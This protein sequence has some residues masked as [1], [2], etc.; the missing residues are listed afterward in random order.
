M[1]KKKKANGFNPE[2]HLS[3]ASRKKEIVLEHSLKKTQ[4]IIAGLSVF[5]IACIALVIF[6]MN[7]DK[8]AG[9][10][11]ASV[12]KSENVTDFPN[13][14][15]DSQAVSGLPKTGEQ[16]NS[17]P[18]KLNPPHGQPGHRC[19]IQVGSPLNSP[20][21]NPAPKNPDPVAVVDKPAEPV[22]Q[23]KEEQNNTN[24]SE[25]TFAKTVHD[26]GT[27]KKES[28]GGCEFAFTNTGTEP[29][30]LSNV[31]SSC[32][33]TVPTWPKDPI[34]PGKSE[35]IKVMYDTKRMGIISK[36]ITVI[37]NAKNGTVILS[38]KGEVTE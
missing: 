26:Y 6:F 23:S 37:S 9:P 38:I 24:E 30:I 8:K 4:W 36:S 1:K 35:I 20:P 16:D 27:I 18:P 3:N 2:K 15:I 28:D 17:N 34:L 7:S 19:D 21:A 13:P 29:L 14:A 22:V 11:K 10:T 5:A 25:V 33:C 12:F 32:G 31:K